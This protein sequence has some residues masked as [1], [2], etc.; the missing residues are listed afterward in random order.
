MPTLRVN[1]TELYYE[2]TGGDGPPLV[3]S[4]GLLWSTKMFAPQI[5]RLR[6][7]FRC[8]AYDHRGQGRS[9]ADPARSISMETCAED[10]AALIEALGLGPCHFLGLSMGGFVAMRL[11]ARR[12]QLLR[13]C[14][15]L[16]TSADPE[17]VPSRKKYRV[18]NL[19]FRTIGPWPVAGAIMKV[20]FGASFF[21][22][23]A[24]AERRRVWHQEVLAA[25]RDI[26]RAVNGVLERDGVYEEIAGIRIPTLVLVGEEDV[27]TIPEKAER[28]AAQ[29][30]GAKLVRI[31][32]AGHTSTIEEPEAVTDAIE[33]FIDSLP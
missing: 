9:A 12:P 1:G 33:R 18:L 32:K 28:I 26:W 7:R 2:D 3:F 16:E 15:L 6:G 29:I 27:A 17:P 4:H 22:D 24:K 8:V 11:A 23:P 30:P 10:A 31:P 13:S 14:L 25:R 21:T 5:E 20:M 19:I